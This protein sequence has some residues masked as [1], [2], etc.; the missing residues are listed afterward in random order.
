MLPALIHSVGG[1]L[2]PKNYR[3]WIFVGSPLTPN[4]LNDGH[5]NFSEYHNVYVGPCWYESYLKTGAFP[6]GTLFISS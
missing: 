2:L 3:E 1:P 5:A 4:G 6:D